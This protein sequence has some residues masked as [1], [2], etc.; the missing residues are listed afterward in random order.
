MTV[1]FDTVHWWSQWGIQIK[2]SDLYSL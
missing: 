1:H 2:I